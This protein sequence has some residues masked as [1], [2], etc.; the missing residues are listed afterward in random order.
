MNF[1]V[2]R[3]PVIYK[4]TSPIIKT[5]RES[6]NEGAEHAANKAFPGLFW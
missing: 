2:A 3:V 4:H 5:Y 6:E 1:E